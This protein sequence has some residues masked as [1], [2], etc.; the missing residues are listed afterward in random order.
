LRKESKKEE[1]MLSQDLEKR[2]RAIEDIEA[3]KKLKYHYAHLVDVRD[4]A[5]HPEELAQ[6][7][8]DD[9]VWGAEGLGQFKGREAIKKF[10]KEADAFSFQ[11]H[12][13]SQPIIEIDSENNAHGRWDMSLPAT[14]KDGTA[15]WVS[16][17]E[18]DKYEKVNGEWLMSEVKVAI[19]FQTPYEEGWHKRRFL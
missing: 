7:F 8:T 16:G 11:V 1:L 6:L 5:S 17:F 14:T 12:Q 4:G 13:F 19:I 10:F 3:I 15:L 9:A 18:E 2:I